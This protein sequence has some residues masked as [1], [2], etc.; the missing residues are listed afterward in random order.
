MFTPPGYAIKVRA[1]VSSLRHPCTTLLRWSP[2]PPMFL[3]GEPRHRIRVHH[4]A[5]MPCFLMVM[6]RA[7]SPRGERGP[8]I[9]HISFVVALDVFFFTAGG[10]ASFFAFTSWWLCSSWRL[11]FLDSAGWFCDVFGISYVIDVT[12]SALSTPTLCLDVLWKARVLLV[13]NY[14]P[15]TCIQLTMFLILLT[16]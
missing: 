16:Q 4:A 14:F 12:R 2:L 13:H 10:T 5:C 1:S 7:A 11:F 15:F 9:R 8:P 3:P 6:A